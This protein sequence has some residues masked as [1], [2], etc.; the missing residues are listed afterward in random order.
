MNAAAA[1]HDMVDLAFALR[2]DAIA[3]DYAWALWLGVRERLAWLD[4]EA[5]AGIHP[6]AG[7][8]G[9]GDRLYLGRRARLTLRLPRARVG[10]AQALAGAVFDLGGRVQVEG[11]GSARPLQASAVLYAPF[12][13]VDRDDEAEFVAECRRLLP[14]CGGDMICGKARS[15]ARGEGTLRGYSVML[16]GLTAA[17]SIDLQC[18]GLGGERRLG[19]GLFMPHKSVAAVGA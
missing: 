8:S 18:A 14:A 17:E 7:V 13:W 16:H 12:V 4:G 19:C 9:A 2:G 10:D 15:A 11:E 3:A 6:L 1:G 5:I